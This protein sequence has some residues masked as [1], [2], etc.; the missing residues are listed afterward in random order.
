MI[1]T[2]YF[3]I[4]TLVSLLFVFS[5][6]YTQVNRLERAPITFDF[7]KTGSAQY[8]NSVVVDENFKYEKSL[9][10]GWSILPLNSFERIKFNGTTLRNNLT[11]DGV[12]GK[13]I[14]FKV[15][16]PSGKWWFTYW[17]EAGND[18]TNSSLLKINDKNHEINWFRIKAGEGGESEH[19]NLYRVYNS[20]IEVDNAGLVVNIKG[21]KDSVRIL[22]L[23]L[24]PYEVPV[25][26]L[27]Q[28]ISRIVKQAGRYKSKVSLADLHKYL[29]EQNKLYPVDSYIYYLLQQSSLFMEADRL[30]NMMGW[31]WASQLTGLGIFDRL[32]QTICLLDAQIEHDYEFKNPY[33]ER[34]LWMRG[35]L[36][37]DLNLQRGGQHEKEMAKRDLAELYELYPDDENLAM[38]NGVV[39]NQTDYCDCLNANNSAPK[40]ATLQRELI[41]RLSREIKWWVTERQ[42][43]N[44]EFGGK[45][46]DDVELLRWWTP[47]LLSGNKYAILGWKK[48]ADEVWQSPK[49]HLGYSKLPIDVEH[50]AE[51]ISDSTP[52]LLFV[53]EDSTYFK[54]LLYTADYF[55]NLWSVKNKYGRRF[56]KS[57]WFSSTEVDER[58]PRNRDVDYNTRALK[59]LRYTAWSSRNPRMINLL[60]EW[61]EAWL[62]IALMTEKGKPRGIIPSSI[63]YYDEAI[64]GDG[65][66]WYNADMLWTYFD[67]EHSVGSM[68]MDQLFFTYT[69]NGN[70]KLL[71]PINMSLEMIK[72]NYNHLFEKVKEGSEV[73]AAQ[74][75][76]SNNGFWN[77]I[78]KW[79]VTTNNADYDSIII[80]HG[81]EFTKYQITGDQKYLIEG[82]NE[83]L[84][85]IRYN[86][87]L[88]T[89]LALHTDRVRTPGADLLKAMLTGDG[90]PE[91]SSPYYSV[92]WEN[93]N[94][95]LA[96]LV[97]HSNNDR[98]CI[99]LFS[100]ENIEINLTAR[101]WRL[102]KGEYNLIYKNAA[103]KALHNKKI[104]I[105]S[106]GQKLD[107]TIPPGQLIIVEITSASAKD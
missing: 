27:H 68:I 98:L 97:T 107:L 56:F 54:R 42:A 95:N 104:M 41:C 100:F 39:I 38:Y 1:S 33:R 5:D 99:E 59:P 78:G 74:K 46:G 19:L 71:E 28:K 23:S 31:E 57:A 102:N 87:P 84:E 43:P 20:L 58:I 18:Y 60:N 73:W 26:D 77:V 45:I 32:H 103:G 40:W 65:T 63:R 94:D 70:I 105:N 7:G 96:S 16:I 44:G 52:E 6:L 14:E 25:S 13:E 101:V 48:L 55:E 80:K 67:W 15:N 24:I 47:F 34:A 21:G 50:A 75:L 106:V 69:L 8:L 92:S 83:S 88:R 22:G 49:V 90:T 12:T 91:G 17:M 76:V 4:I 36:G 37:Y 51:F 30:N 82:L 79:R 66:N 3:L 89:T 9:G 86:T 64:N 29:L 62:H 35:K 81:N 61:S 10:F 85:A 72:K 2:K 53:D 11:N 93:R